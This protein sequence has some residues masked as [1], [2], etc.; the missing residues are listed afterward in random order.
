MEKLCFSSDLDI[1]IKGDRGQSYKVSVLLVLSG[2]IT[3]YIVHDRSL[4][5]PC[6]KMPTFIL[7]LSLAFVF[8]LIC[9]NCGLHY[10]TSC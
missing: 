7:T 9:H 5:V 4:S 1:N 3:N 10:F 6:D 8:V 2:Y